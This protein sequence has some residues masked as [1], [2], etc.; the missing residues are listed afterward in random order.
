MANLDD[1]PKTL[2]FRVDLPPGFEPVA[3]LIFEQRTLAITEGVVVDLIGPYGTKSFRIY[4]SAYLAALQTLRTGNM[5]LNPSFE[6]QHH[7]GFPDS[8]LIKYGNGGSA[9]SD[10]TFAHSG[11]T[12]I[13]LINPGILSTGGSLDLLLAGVES[14]LGA[15]VIGNLTH[16]VSVFARGNTVGLPLEISSCVGTLQTTLTTAWSEYRVVG[17]VINSV[18]CSVKVTLAQPGTAWIDSISLR[19]GKR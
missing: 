13:R 9:L 17:S 16:T 5:V 11:Y 3:E 19:E 1:V 8:Y 6:I 10:P 14:F 15:R 18:L 7:T 4:S 12:S 2:Q